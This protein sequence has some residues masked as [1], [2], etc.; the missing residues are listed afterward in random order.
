M[1]RRAADLLVDCLVAH[2]TDR[3]FCV[4][5]ESYLSA[6]DALHGRNEI[7][8]IV[9]RHESG[10]G[11]MAVA[12]AK[13]TGRPG[14]AFVSRGPGATNASIAVHVSEQDAV[15]LILFI[16]Q[17][18]RHDIGRHAF[19]EVD[20]V[21]TFS[22]M[23]KGVW[24]VEDAKRL[25]EIV[26]RAFQVAQSPTPGPCVIVLPEDMLDDKTTASVIDPLGIARPGLPSDLSAITAAIAKAARPL[27]IAGGGVGSAR[28]RLALLAAAEALQLPVAA[29]FKRQEYFPNTHV[30]YAGHLGFK[31]PKAQ[32]DNYLDADLVIA[33]G[34][35][36]G[37]TPTQGYT[38][39]MAPVPKQP[40][41]HVYDDAA[42]VGRV[43]QTAYPVVRHGS[44][45]GPRW[46]SGIRR[47]RT[48]GR[49]CGSRAR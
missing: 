41:I 3:V 7:E 31:I 48:P 24:L 17:V 11:F 6:L 28:G 5:G 2:G 37:E 18:P 45:T 22:D 30:L 19:Q 4:P 33:V 40:L 34:T 8:T 16:G 44:A 49:R 32:L 20:Y 46:W 36:L 15:P 12:D 9:C 29:S 25:P 38:F 39:P 27:L 26:A 35:R 42:Q 21:K 23:A 13:I 47:A 14:I 10:A 43:F 1:S